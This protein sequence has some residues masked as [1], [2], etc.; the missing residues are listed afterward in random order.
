[1]VLETAMES[2]FSICD[3]YWVSKL[4]T[5]ATAAIGLTESVLTLYYALAVGLSIAVTAM[6]SR[7]IGEKRPEAAA[8]VAAQTIYMGLFVGIATGIACWF[9]A[10]HVLR[11][12]GASAEI[13]K[14]GSGYARI[15][16]STNVVILM[17]FLN[18]AIFRG[19]G[20]PAL[21]MRALWLGNGI[22]LVLD[23]MLIFGFGPI[24]AMGLT[25]A[26][27]ASVTGRSVAVLYQ[28]YQLRRGTGQVRLVGTALK[29]DGAIIR[30]LVRVSVG[31]IAQMAVATS[32]WVIMMRYMAKFGSD[33]LA[34]YTIGIRI[35]IFTILPS[36]GLSNAAA[37][38]VGQH[39][40][41]KLPDRAA[42]AV[43]ITGCYNMAFMMVV[44]I[45]FVLFGDVFVG[46]F[47]KDPEVIAIGGQCLRVF[48]YGYL[49]YGWGM[50]MTQAFNGAGDTTTPTWINLIAFW[51]FQLPF[52]WWL[53][54][55][56]GHGPN[57][58]F[59]AVIGADTLLT[60]MA[61]IMFMRGT[62]KT[63]VV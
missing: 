41:A 62:W 16:L 46:F 9:A 17:L 42:R 18:N 13:I 25:G 53:A 8:K 51:I 40:G 59:W 56:Q 38:L 43:W 29:R 14:E 20:D 48:S 57:G 1:M 36:W 63:R 34:G 26:A 22:N 44:T 47:S 31:G 12:M 35:V 30:R 10:P 6:V 32:S 11:W 24:P 21:A 33:A 52:A 23:P 37:T 15:I 3:I 58:I 54:F 5:N 45:N 49:L 2:L 28:I 19:A 60:V 55:S 4:G 7:R 39:L 61:F 27:I 50:V